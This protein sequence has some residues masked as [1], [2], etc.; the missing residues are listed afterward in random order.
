M[1]IIDSN[2]KLF[3]KIS[4]LDII[5]VAVVVFLGVVFALNVTNKSELP[6]SVSSDLQ[7]TTVIK[8]Y[9]VFKTPKSPFEVGD[10][11]YTQ[12]GEVIGKIVNIDARTGYTKEK[13]LDGTY[14]DF[15]TE[16]YIDYYLTV[17]GNGTYTDKGYKAQ[18][19]FLLCPNETINVATKLFYGNVVV[20]SVEK[21]N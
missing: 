8:A 4:I 15:E 10:V 19:S 16:D 2:G 20:L 13:M 5:I 17:E 1:K 21:N 7:Y 3:G 14:I 12:S 11:M 18:G 9:N 6:V